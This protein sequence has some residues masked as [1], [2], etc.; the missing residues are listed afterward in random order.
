MVCNYST[1]YSAKAVGT[2]SCE[3]GPTGIGWASASY[4]LT[5]GAMNASASSHASG[6]G[7][8]SVTARDEYRVMGIA[9]G[10][11]LTITARL[12]LGLVGCSGPPFCCGG[13]AWGFIRGPDGTAEDLYSPH[14]PNSCASVYDSVEVVVTVA[15]GEPFVMTFGVAA[16]GGETGSGSGGGQLHFADLPPG[17]TVESCHGYRQD[18]PTPELRQT[19]GRI[20]ARYR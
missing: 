20:K 11:P 12:R 9:Q 8:G 1:I 17:A 4:D 16:A 14:A 19:W 18:S 2:V 5:V 6:N 7:Y 13:G 10:T 3:P 15:S